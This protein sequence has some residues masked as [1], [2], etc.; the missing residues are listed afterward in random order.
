MPDHIVLAILGTGLMGGS[1]GLACRKRGLVERVIGYDIQPDRLARAIER[2]A[3]T[4]AAESPRSAVREA[5]LTVIASPVGSIP[6]VFAEI[7]GQLPQD[8]IVTDVGSTKSRVVEDIQALA[9]ADVHFI[10]GHPIAGSEHEGIDAADADLY[11]GAFW[12]LTPTRETDTAA[13]GRLVRFLAR[14][15]AHVLSLDPGRHDELVA[16]TSH[17]PQLLSSTLMGFAADIAASE[18]GLPLVTAGGF[19]DMTRIAGSSPD[20]WVDIVRE[21]RRAILELLNRFQGALAT[22]GSY[23][24]AED[25]EGLRRVLVGA[26]EGRKNLP[27][28]PGLAPA[29]IVELKVVV[30]DHPGSLAAVTTTVGEAGVNIEDF[31][32]VH[33]LEGGKGTIHLTLNG[34]PAARNAKEALE[35]KGFTAE[36]AAN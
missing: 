32:V 3:I 11:T 10:G 16:L 8:A 1:L 19:R 24:E 27:D 14:L 22:A 15:D 31:Y 36:L 13:Y 23:V 20:L 33:S 29:C 18:G 21:N 25:W 6:G 17:L 34:E 30:L 4:E 12:I 2:G 7:A 9:P 35:K 28:K 5:T 26:R